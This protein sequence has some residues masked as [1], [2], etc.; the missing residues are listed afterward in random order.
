M[1]ADSSKEQDYVS[2]LIDPNAVQDVIYMSSV[3]DAYK[4]DDATKLTVGDDD[5]QRYV[6]LED[7]DMDLKDLLAQYDESKEETHRKKSP[8]KITFGISSSAMRRPLYAIIRLFR[9][10]LR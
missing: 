8:E 3:D 1:G 4:T 7:H 6:I 10:M 9:Y 2:S 5:E